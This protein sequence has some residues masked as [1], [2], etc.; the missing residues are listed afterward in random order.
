MGERTRSWL[1]QEAKLPESTIG[2]AILN[3][4]KKT[5][6]AIK[7]AA[8][9]GVSLEWLLLGE[10]QPAYAS[11][12]ELRKVLGERNGGAAGAAGEDLNLVAIASIDQAYGLGGTF[13]DSPVNEQVQHFPRPWIESITR[14]PAKMLT[15][16]YGRGDS[17][18]PSIN[19]GDL[20]L[21]DRSQK[22]V[23]EQDAYWALTIGDIGMIKR[24]RVRG[25]TIHILSDNDRVPPDV[26][27]ADEVN[28]VGRVIFIGRRL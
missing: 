10:V 26:A 7:I 13:T 18:S 3:G 15:W 19:D 16:T 14:S 5:E 25:D 11:A 4:P 6:V 12:D 1:A 23:L 28:I 8:A 2:D 21:L 20:I 24:L 27:T 17:M 22:N 9:L